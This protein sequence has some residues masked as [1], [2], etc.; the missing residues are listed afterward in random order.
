VKPLAYACLLTLVAGLFAVLAQPV[1]ACPEP[2]SGDGIATCSGTTSVP[3]PS[4][5]GGPFCL[6]AICPGLKGQPVNALCVE[7]WAGGRP[8]TTEICVPA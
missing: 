5:T 6:N 4:T 7:G 2:T 8:W 3:E 1:S